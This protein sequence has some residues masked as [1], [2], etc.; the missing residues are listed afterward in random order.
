MKYGIY[1]KPEVF[2]CLG[3]SVKE[4]NDKGQLISN[5]ADQGLYGCTCQ[6]LGEQDGWMNIV[7]SYGYAGCIRKDDLIITDEAGVRSWLDGLSVTNAVWTDVLTAPTVHG[8][9]I[10]SLPRGSAVKPLAGSEEDGWIKVSLADGNEGYVPLVRLS[11]KRYDDS[12]L[13]ADPED[14]TDRQEMAVKLRAGEKGGQEGFELKKILDKY[15][16]G[17]EEAFR[18]ELL[19][20]AESYLGTQYRWAGRSSSG[21]DCSGMVS[22]CYLMAGIVIYRD[23][24]IVRGYPI[25]RLDIKMT[26]G[27]FDLCNLDDGSMRP[28]DALYFPGHIAMY[29]GDGLYIHSTGRAGSN[30]VVYNS[31][32][33]EHELFR[34]DLLESLYAVG[35][36]R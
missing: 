30:G 23:A 15:Y 12:L 35:G 19:K 22:M 4:Y 28:G 3:T 32:R 7:S 26:D 25:K 9:L 29:A 20:L 34:A 21:I 27:H 6:I 33:P 14:L 2:V 8:S 24:S 1:N 11:E 17:S 13:W 10:L 16:G 5:M 31:L 18:S 36:V